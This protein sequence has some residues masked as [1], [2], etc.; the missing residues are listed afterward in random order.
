[1]TNELLSQEIYDFFEETL[2]IFEETKQ[3]TV[4]IDK[5]SNG[6]Q[7]PLIPIN[8][9]RGTLFHLY[10]V[11]KKPDQKAANFLEAKEHIY[12][13][14]FDTYSILSSILINKISESVSE[15]KSSTLA[16]AFPNYH[17]QLKPQVIFIQTQIGQIRADRETNIDID[18]NGDG[19]ERQKHIKFLV[20]IL[21][22]VESMKP[23][24]HQFEM[25]Q[26]KA[27]REERKL[28]AD[29]EAR[30]KRFKLVDRALWLIGGILLAILGL[31]LK[32]NFGS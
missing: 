3:Y 15:F 5:L 21:A 6:Q 8:E 9:L 13:A 4:L 18:K 32:N 26:L 7:V 17:Q 30:D 20:H 31:Y 16:E 28:E 2:P 12:R 14:C 27:K 24:L 25:E 1:M 11:I 10:K 19:D 29:K 23:H 22:Q